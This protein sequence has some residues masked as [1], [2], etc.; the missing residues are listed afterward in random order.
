MKISLNWLKDYVDLSD[1]TA[2]EIASALTN[3]TCEVEGIEHR[4]GGLDTVVVGRVLTCTAH[5]KSDH[6]HLLTVDIGTAQPLQIVCGAPN[7]RA[8]ITVAVAAVG[9]KLPNGLEIKESEIRG[10][11]SCGMCCSYAELDYS[12]E[13]EGIAELPKDSKTGAK[14]TDIIPD[15]TDDILDIDNKSITNRPDLW[16]HYGVA[17]ELSVIFNRRFK[18]SKTDIIKK[19]AHLPP[20]DIKIENGNCLSYRAVKVE[21]IG[22]VPSPDIIQNRL[23]YCGHNS[24]GFLVDITN[25]VMLI[26]GNPT[27]AFDARKIGKI[28]IG[29]LPAGTKFVTLKDNQIIA[30][31]DMLF[32]KSDGEPVTLAGIMGGK[33]SEIKPDTKD[34]V[35]EVATFNAVNIRRTSTAAGL[36]TDASARYE[37]SLDP[38]TNLLAGAEILRLVNKYAKAASV[39]SAFDGAVRGSRTDP[40]SQEIVVKK[41]YLE[42]F[43]GVKFDYKKVEKDLKGLGFSPIITDAEIKVTVPSYRNWKDIT[44]PNDIIEEIVRNFGYQNIKPAA[45]CVAVKP[46]LREPADLFDDAVKDLFALKYGFSEV[47]TNIW[48]NTQSCKELNIAPVSHLSVINS[49]VKSDSSVRSEILTSMLS[50]VL[51]NKTVNEIRIFEIGRVIS[52]L[53][54]SGNG[55]EEKRLGGVRS[56]KTASAEQ[57]YKETAYML[58]DIFALRGFVLTYKIG[59]AAD[60]K[61][62]PKN[63]AGIY[64]RRPSYKQETRERQGNSDG[65]CANR[66]A[67]SDERKIGEFGIINPRVLKDTVGFEINLSALDWTDMPQITMPKMTKYPKTELD[68]TFIWDGIFADLDRI[69]D[70]NSNE[71][72]LNRRLSSVY[73]NR[74]TVTF[75]VGSYDKTLTG[76]EIGAIHAE[77]MNF[78]EQNGVKMAKLG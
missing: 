69:L 26:Y 29:N 78:A 60:E 56:T 28:S 51:P 58:R 38:Q 61:F 50:A 40:I 48:Y 49:F 4:G 34:A 63:N 71:F 19:Y 31:K 33:D 17:R 12:G 18:E 55:T 27:H 65:T 9:T 62:H 8:G 35:F 21:N 39:V 13:N 77:I 57:I 52:G 76:G 3:K 75:T 41:D 73:G 45:P 37:K 46:V 44:A 47:H 59:D 43:A 14:I 32:V 10:E 16:G 70:R 7:A 11:R 15:L 74:F 72:V 42:R 2:A 20:L 64:I 36:R 6:L 67:K 30:A 54:K 22:G 23:W 1:L 66:T 24:H 68:F 53:D 25:Y 5:P